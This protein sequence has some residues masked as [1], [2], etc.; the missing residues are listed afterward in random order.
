MLKN[1]KKIYHTNTNWNMFVLNKKTSIQDDI[2]VECY[3]TLKKE[4]LLIPHKHS[5]KLKTEYFPTHS[6]TNIIPVSKPDRKKQSKEKNKSI[7]QYSSWHEH[8]EKKLANQIQQF[9]K[10]SILLT[11]SYQVVHNFHLSPYRQC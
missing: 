9:I 2:M 4:I 1:G 3:Q 7:Y 6:D 8:R 11:A 5:R 10:S